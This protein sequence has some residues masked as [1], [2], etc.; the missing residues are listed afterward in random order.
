MSAL[1][2]VYDHGFKTCLFIA[3]AG[4]WAFCYGLARWGKR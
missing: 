3:T 2:V 4:F 1:Q